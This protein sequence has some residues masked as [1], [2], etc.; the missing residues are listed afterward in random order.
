[1]ISSLVACLRIAQRIYILLSMPL[2]PTIH[3]FNF[4]LQLAIIKVQNQLLHR[5]FRF[6]LKTGLNF[7][8]ASRLIQFLIQWSKFTLHLPKYRNSYLKSLPLETAYVSTCSTI[9]LIDK[10]PYIV[11]VYNFGS[12]LVAN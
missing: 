3:L 1:L 6:S 7:C 8:I 2:H 12:D 10:R 4:P 9:N 11:S 5:C